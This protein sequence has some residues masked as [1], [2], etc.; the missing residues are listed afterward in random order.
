MAKQSA[1]APRLTVQETTSAISLQCAVDLSIYKSIVRTFEKKGN[2]N[3]QSRNNER[4]VDSK[5]IP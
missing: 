5:T 3:C 4:P 2:W 1:D